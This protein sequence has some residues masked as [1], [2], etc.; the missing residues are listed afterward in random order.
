MRNGLIY[1]DAEYDE[2]IDVHRRGENLCNISIL[3]SLFN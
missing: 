1:Y 2:Q 3:L